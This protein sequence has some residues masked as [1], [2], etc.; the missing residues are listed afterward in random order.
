L[1]DQPGERG[2][3]MYYGYGVG[4]LIVL[5]LLILLLTGRI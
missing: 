5:I 1:L 2:A 4:G 3:L